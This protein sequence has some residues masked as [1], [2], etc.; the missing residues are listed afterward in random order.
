MDD[1][2]SEATTEILLI[3]LTLLVFLISGLVF[4]LT[5]F[6]TLDEIRPENQRLS[7]PK[8][9][10]QLIPVY[11]IVWQFFV[12][13][14]ISDSIRAEL[15]APVGDSIF[16]EESV[17]ANV[18]PTFAVGIAYATCFCVGIL[19]IDMIKGAASLLGIIFWITYWIQL[20]KYK[21]KII[22]RAK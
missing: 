22:K 7:P 12:I 16:P 5:Q 18:R 15:N 19:P 4:L 14:R 1:L 9:W 13:S 17:P 6:R 8:V 11:G 10:L 20:A 2:N 21:R 3:L